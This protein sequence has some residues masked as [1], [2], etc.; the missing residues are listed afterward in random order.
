MIRTVVLLGA[1][2]IPVGHRVDVHV[3]ARDVGVFGTDIQ[4]VPDEPLVRDLDTGIWYGRAWHVAPGAG[5]SI[6]EARSPSP[7][8]G[9]HVV[10]QYRAVVRAC[11][12]VSEGISRE[13]AVAT[14]LHL[15]IG[16]PAV[17]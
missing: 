11:V 16:G 4:P 2:P 13:Q 5:A 8:A 1:M 9:V 14:T 6:R 15:E 3:L 7:A 17:A 12:V 10:E